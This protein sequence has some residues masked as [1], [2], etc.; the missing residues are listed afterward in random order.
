MKGGTDL[1][2]MVRDLH[3]SRFMPDSG[4]DLLDYEANDLCNDL[5]ERVETWTPSDPGCEAHDALV[6]ALVKHTLADYGCPEGQHFEG[7][8]FWGRFAGKLSTWRR[9]A[10]T[11][12]DRA[13]RAL[14]RC[15]G[16][17]EAARQV[18][19][20]LLDDDFN[21]PSPGLDDPAREVLADLEQALLETSA[22][23]LKLDHLNVSLLVDDEES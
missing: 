18:L 6:L 20:D 21:T 11:E 14:A 7:K 3:A 2:S 15:R 12:R 9:E 5:I 1:F 8:G 17:M 19:R 22:E 10:L 4:F 13:I 16:E 23:A